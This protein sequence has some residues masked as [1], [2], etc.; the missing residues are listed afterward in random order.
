MRTLAASLGLVVVLALPAGAQRFGGTWVMQAPTGPI[1]LTLTQA[2]GGRTTGTLTIEGDVIQ[3]G[4]TIAQGRL[5]GQASLG[6]R[7]GVFEAAV[8]GDQ[9]RAG[10]VLIAPAG[11]HLRISRGLGATLSADAAGARHVPSVDVLFRSAERARPGKVLGVLLTGMGEDGAEG[12]SLIRAHGG[13]TI[14]ESEATCAVYGMPRAAVERG[15]AQ[16]VLP[17]PAIA[18]ALAALG[19]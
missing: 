6:A 13:V 3:L 9:L 2:A 19:S 10:R 15:A 17:L 4:G 11:M 12:L 18:A 7:R 5:S 1:T 14:A 16:H 8:E